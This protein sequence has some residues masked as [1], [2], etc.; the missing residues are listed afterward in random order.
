MNILQMILYPI[1][2]RFV[3]GIN[4]RVRISILPQH[5]FYLT[6]FIGM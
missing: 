1:K 5:E 4:D 6:A 3:S 2:V